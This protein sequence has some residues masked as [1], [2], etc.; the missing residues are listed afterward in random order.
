MSDS[1]T[2]LE[3][4]RKVYS[5]FVAPSTANHSLAGATR[6]P[7]V[8]AHKKTISPLASGWSNPLDGDGTMLRNPVST[9]KSRLD[10]QSSSALS[11]AN[12]ISREAKML[13]RLQSKS[14]HKGLLSALSAALL[15]IGHTAPSAN[16]AENIT[17]GELQGKWQ[18]TLLWSNSGCGPMSGLLNFTFGTNGTTSTATL[19]TNSGKTSAGL[20]GPSTSTQSFTVQSLK[21]NGSGTAGLTC[22]EGCGWQFNIQVAPNVSIFNLVDVD[23]ANPGNYVEGTAIRQ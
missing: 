17:I 21:P 11:H 7:N 22:G 10:L 1:Q 2:A 20:C 18:A 3:Q 19:T 16:A 23:P 13:T 12:C 5:D 6:R 4:L 8:R 15:A 9:R 14:A